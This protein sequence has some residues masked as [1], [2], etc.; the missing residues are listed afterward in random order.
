MD[1]LLVLGG[2]IGAGI[3][4][5]NNN[6][7]NLDNTSTTNGI[8]D[9]PNHDTV[10]DTN[11][12]AMSKEI[13]EVT[14]ADMI[15][16][17]RDDKSKIID[18]AQSYNNQHRNVNLNIG[19]DSIYSQ[20]LDQEI[21][22]DEFLKNDQGFLT[23]PYFKGNAP[24]EIDYENNYGFQASMGGANA[25][26]EWRSKKEVENLFGF[27][28]N[29]ENIYGKQ[30]GSG[31]DADFNR[32]V[33]G[34]MRTGELPF[35]QVKVQ[36]I[37]EKSLDNRLV[38]EAIAKTRNIDN[39][40]TLNNQKK[41]YTGRVID[42]ERI[43]F[44]GIEGQVNKNKTE[45]YH[46]L[47]EDR[48]LVT[49]GA[50]LG[51]TKRPRQI[52]PDTNRQ[53]LNKMQLGPASPLDGIEEHTDRPY[54]SKSMKTPLDPDTSRNVT[55]NVK[56]IDYDRLGYTSYPN[57]REVTEERTYQSNIKAEYEGRTLGI[58]DELKKTIK[59][60]TLEPANNGFLTGGSE[61]TKMYNLD[62]VRRTV[63]ETTVGSNDL[64]N[65]KG[66]VT[67]GL[68]VRPLDDLKTTIK[69]GT[70]YDKKGIAGSYI[71]EEMSRTN[72]NNLETN[73]TKEIIS[74][75]AGR[76]PTLS[77]TKLFNGGDTVNI[78]IK[79]IESD[80]VTQRT[81]GIDKIYDN[82]K[83][84][85]VTEITNDKNNYNDAEL[86]LN[87]IDPSILDPFKKNPYTKPLNSYNY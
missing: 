28:H 60:T 31:I 72:Y 54:V 77:S 10:Y 82:Y 36:H 32:Y 46:E 49:T 22:T 5:D 70:M 34:T 65:L 68:E 15:N 4:L 48:N 42:G 40:R 13:E 3:Y 12:Y 21:K 39:L 69:E 26:T 56:I 6:K 24:P 62:G 78:D 64:L 9:T 8:V 75:G 61:K 86:L 35:E 85:D 71:N 51:S 50:V 23:V 83:S 30:W 74:S 52:I 2:I 84:R 37:D 11:N 66:T 7:K 43:N 79:K 29:P 80:Y 73:P 55:G 27:G 33:P 47:G 59:E 67:S 19:E 25:T 38:G 87:Q 81:T 41:T 57:E 18:S 58:Q 20:A 63:K 14:A 45:K 76:P 16:R 1:A 53:Y 17:L 44:R